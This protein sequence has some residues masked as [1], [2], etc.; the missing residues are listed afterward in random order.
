MKKKDLKAGYTL[1]DEKGRYWHLLQFKDGL[2][3]R[4]IQD[5]QIS[6]GVN[7]Y[8]ELA[9][10]DDLSLKTKGMYPDCDIVKVY[11]YS[12]YPHIL[13][14][15]DFDDVEVLWERYPKTKVTLELTD[16][17]IESLKKQ[18]IL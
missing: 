6:D 9:L 15:G 7:L 12:V 14:K 8:V 3:G 16:E 2:H 5:Y 13:F 10:N 1:L 17:Q 4:I 11:G 18:G